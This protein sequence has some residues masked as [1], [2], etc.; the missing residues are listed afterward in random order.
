MSCHI[1]AG[2]LVSS[3]RS[4]RHLQQVSVRMHHPILC[5]FSGTFASFSR[6]SRFYQYCRIWVSS[7][8]Q[9]F[10][11]Y[12][13]LKVRSDK[14]KAALRTAP[15]KGKWQHEIGC[16]PFEGRFIF[17]PLVEYQVSPTQR[18]THAFHAASLFGSSHKSASTPLLGVKEIANGVENVRDR[19]RSVCASWQRRNLKRRKPLPNVHQLLKAKPLG[20]NLGRG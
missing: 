6:I 7:W 13:E 19:S 2:P 18:L 14:A 4:C 5:C 15:K 20:E 10:L 17:G 12:T 11:S 16:F 3:R 8:P 1:S 9:G